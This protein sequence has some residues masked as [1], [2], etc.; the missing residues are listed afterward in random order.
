MQS[1]ST[2]LAATPAAGA[3]VD[4]AVFIILIG[5][6]LGYLAAGSLGGSPVAKVIGLGVAGLIGWPMLQLILASKGMAP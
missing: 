5:L 1:A 4:G 3:P 2:F 6:G